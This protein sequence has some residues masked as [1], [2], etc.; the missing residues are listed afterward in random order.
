MG[1][2]SSAAV[3]VVYLITK[4]FIP[5]DIIAICTTLAVITMIRVLFHY[6][7]QAFIS[8]VIFLLF[9]LCYDL[10]WIAVTKQSF[11]D[12]ISKIDG[13]QIETPFK[14]ALPRLMDSPYTN[15]ARI[16]L[17]DIVIPCMLARYLRSFDYSRQDKFSRYW[18][19]CMVGHVAGMLTWCLV[20]IWTINPLPP[21]IFIAPMSLLPI[22]GYSFWIKD[23]K[24]LMNSSLDKK[25]WSSAP[26]NLDGSVYGDIEISRMSN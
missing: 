15:C 7:I 19:V 26:Q 12:D 5:N 18:I 13:S 25:R 24:A 4:H 2:L 8:G 21:F 3:S 23:W 1:F 17:G 11:G 14:I 20:Q 10:L 6:Q 16:N 9:M 22:L